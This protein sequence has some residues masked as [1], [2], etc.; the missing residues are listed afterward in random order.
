MANDPRDIGQ[1]D[2]NI[3]EAS[4][5]RSMPAEGGEEFSN[6]PPHMRNLVEADAVKQE[7]E[8]LYESGM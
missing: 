5:E 8:G 2:D 7:K 3:I 6:R 4:D 1:A